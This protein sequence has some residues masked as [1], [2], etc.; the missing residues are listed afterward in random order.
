MQGEGKE[1]ENG[2]VGKRED[3]RE[4]VVK[5]GKCELMGWKEETV[6]VYASVFGNVRIFYVLGDYHETLKRKKYCF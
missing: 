5:V 6:Y 1:K 2:E 3:K 4:M